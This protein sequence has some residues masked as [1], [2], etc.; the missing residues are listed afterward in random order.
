MPDRRPLLP[1]LAA[2]AAGFAAVSVTVSVTV[3]VA[4]GAHAFAQRPPAGG[5]PSGGGAQYEEDVRAVARAFDRAQ[6]AGDS[7]TLAR[8]LADD[9]VYVRG[10]GALAGKREFLATFADPQFRLDPFTVVRPTFVALGPDAAIVGGE[11]TLTGTTAAGR[12]AQHLRFAD[13][14]L[15]RRRRWQVVHVQVTEVR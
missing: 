5:V 7:A 10:S 6:L 12:F 8:L 13:T 14:F 9:L 15:R 3:I 4:G 1:P 2:W 11:T